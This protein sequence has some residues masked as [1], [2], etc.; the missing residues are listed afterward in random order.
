MP[1]YLFIANY[2]AE[3]VHG[4]SKEG[5]TGRRKAVEKLAESVGGTLVSFDYAFGADDAFVIVDLPDNNAAAA[6]ALTVSGSGTA[7]VRTVPLLTPEDLDAAV[8]MTP[9]YRPPG[10]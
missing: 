4:L 10:G 1:R 2:T 3:G 6:T 7:T 5:G 8:A 9:S